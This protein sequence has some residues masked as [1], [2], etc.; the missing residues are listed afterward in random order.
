M[1][2]ADHVVVVEHELDIVVDGLD[3][4]NERARRL[5]GVDGRVDEQHDL[6]VAS[7]EQLKLGHRALDVHVGHVVVV[8]KV[9]MAAQHLPDALAVALLVLDGGRQLV[10]QRV[11]VV[12][13]VVAELVELLEKVAIHE[14]ARLDVG[15]G[16][17]SIVLEY[18]VGRGQTVGGEL[19]APLVGHRRVLERA[20]E[21]QAAASGLNLAARVDVELF[22]V[23][24]QLVR[25]LAEDAIAEAG[26]LMH[27]HV[28]VRT[29]E[30][31]GPAPVRQV[32]GRKVDVR[33][34]LAAHRRVVHHER[35]VDGEVV[36]LLDAEVGA[37]VRLPRGVGQAAVER[38]R[39][40]VVEVVV[41]SPRV[42]YEYDYLL[43]V[44]ALPILQAFYD[45]VNYIYKSVSNFALDYYLVILKRNSDASVN[46]R[47][48]S[49]MSCW[50]SRTPSSM[51]TI[52]LV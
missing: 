8:A 39:V 1:Y 52:R 34:R 15:V 14:R 27:E 3:D 21:T 18:A 26:P 29:V 50:L 17:L 13:L 30:L 40:E 42:R 22:V 33:G 49:S 5:L 9:R 2:D 4:R 25:I 24:G 43:E 46:T 47:L 7:L 31:L 35:Y 12:G 10:V 45:I 41:E 44:D 23:L 16:R 28:G 11:Q 37:I 38:V 20:A 36:A 19:V 51:P 6:T 32:V 48:M